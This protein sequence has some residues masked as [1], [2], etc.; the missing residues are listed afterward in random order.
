MLF[1]SRIGELALVLMCSLAFNS[2][3]SGPARIRKSVAKLKI[4]D[5]APEYRIYLLTTHESAVQKYATAEDSIQI[6]VFE[7]KKETILK[8]YK[9]YK[10]SMLQLKPGEQLIVVLHD[11]RNQTEDTISLR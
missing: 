11:G 5:K 3:N 6:T 9:G 4:N 1:M 2:C 7:K 8:T 10:Y